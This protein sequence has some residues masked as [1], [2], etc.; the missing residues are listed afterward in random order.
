LRIYKKDIEAIALGA[1]T[2]GAGGGGDT[3]AGILL[4]KLS[5]SDED[6]IELISAEDVPDDATVTCVS[7]LGAPVVGLEKLENRGELVLAFEKLEKHLGTKISAVLPAE[8]G[9]ANCLTPF[10]VALEK[11]IPVVDADGLGRAFPQVEQSTFTLHNLP[12]SPCSQADE[13]GNSVIFE[14]I[15][16]NWAET[17]VSATVVPMGGQTATCDFSMKGKELKK[18][19][20]KNTVSLALK[21]GQNII[22]AR[23]EEK[24]LN[25]AV[26]EATNGILLFQGKI[27]DV[28]MDVGG[29]FNIGKCVIEGIDSFESRVME[30]EYRNEY[31]IAKETTEDKILAMAPDLITIF[32]SKT[33]EPIVAENLKYGNQVSVLGIPC[34]SQWRTKEGLALAGIR[35]F[36]YD[37]TYKSLEELN[38][39]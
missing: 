37:L 36:G 3:T 13:K 7:Y 5:M 15:D 34:D 29:R 10:H 22:K 1:T 19:A 23:E 28:I 18:A 11:N 12:I 26:V 24:N 4:L 31:M 9:G 21:I 20:I 35:S 25:D 16:N 8:V 27:T 38:R 32:H 39:W 2:L 14:T 30:V 17:L 6:Y 33:G